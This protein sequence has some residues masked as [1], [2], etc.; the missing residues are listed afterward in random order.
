M[1]KVHITRQLLEGKTKAAFKVLNQIR[2][3][4]MNQA[5]YVSGETLISHQDPRRLLIVSTWKS[6]ENWNRWK[7]SPER[8]ALVSH[9]QRLESRPAEHQVYLFGT[10][11]VME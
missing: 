9:M 10:Y 1:V 4:A 8:K 11:P 6:L 5:G 3:A 7:D 2:A